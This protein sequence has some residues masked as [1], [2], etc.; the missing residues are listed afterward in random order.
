[1]SLK[2]YKVNDYSEFKTNFDTHFKI[3][4]VR[5]RIC[6]LVTYHDWNTMQVRLILTTFYSPVLK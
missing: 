3:F 6:T 4:V 5:A 1:M 2:W